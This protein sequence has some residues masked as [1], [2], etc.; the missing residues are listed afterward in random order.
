MNYTLMHR[1]I[2][3]AEIDI[4]LDSATIL[5]IGNIIAP[6]HMPIGKSFIDNKPNRAKLDEWWRS[7][8]I[9]A[10]RQNFRE[11]MEGLGISSS[12]ELLTKCF[13]LSLSDQYWVNPTENPLKWEDVNFFDNPF[14]D[15]VGNVLFGNAEQGK[16]ISLFSPD[17]TSDG[18]L[19]KKWKII[20]GK[21][22]L[23]K[24][25][26]MPFHQEPL[27]EACATA[28]MKRLNIPHVPYSVFV[29]DELPYSVCDDF[30]NSETDLVSAYNIST[31]LKKQN[32]TSSYQHYLD[33]CQKLGIPNA[34]EDIDKMLTLDYLILNEDRHYN[35]FGAVRNAITLEWLGLAPVF[36]SGTSL[37]YNQNQ[38]SNSPHVL[39]RMTTKPFRTTYEEQIKL[40][41]NFSWLDSSALNGISDEFSAILSHSLYIDEKRINDIC[42]AFNTRVQFLSQH[43]QNI[44]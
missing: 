9:P 17:N 22:C 40:V 12:E 26:S 2:E 19:K 44:T 10:S 8:S 11:A 5:K 7:R 35:N 15:D 4:E 3:V 43:I 25:G 34:Q 27:N 16:E 38:I 33:C 36:D 21:R 29:D 28:V 41:K 24:G 1:K 6:E 32:N 31:A 42:V 14:S 30:I 18:W 13:G 20:D 37:W 23:V 39:K